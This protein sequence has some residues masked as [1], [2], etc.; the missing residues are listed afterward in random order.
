M[1]AETSDREKGRMNKV[2]ITRG[3]QKRK[4]T[5]GESEKGC[6]ALAKPG[7]ND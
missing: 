2:E 7:R 1:I 3:L 5:V 6:L 4:S